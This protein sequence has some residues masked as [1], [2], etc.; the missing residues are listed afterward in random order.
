MRK[1]Q[2]EAEFEPHICGRC[3]LPGAGSHHK[4]DVYHMACKLEVKLDEGE[5]PQPTPVMGD[6]KRKKNGAARFK[7]TF[8]GPRT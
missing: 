3:G 5:L 6:T 7:R 1:Q 4:G 8:G 2:N